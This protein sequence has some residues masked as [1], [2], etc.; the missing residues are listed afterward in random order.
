MN[1]SKEGSRDMNTY[2]EESAF[3]KGTRTVDGKRVWRHLQQIMETY[4]SY[5]GIAKPHQRPLFM[6]NH[7]DHCASCGLILFVFFIIPEFFICTLT[8]Q[9]YNKYILIMQVFILQHKTKL[10]LVP[11]FFKPIA[12]FG[13]SKSCKQILL[14]LC[15]SLISPSCYITLSKNTPHPKQ[16]VPV[17]LPELLIR[18]QCFLTQ[19]S[20]FAQCYL[21]FVGVWGGGGGGLLWYWICTFWTYN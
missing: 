19:L 21:P 18:G 9:K 17:R 20:T 8:I 16:P 2:R 6:W 11:P 5:Q 7:G 15:K 14:I 3:G 12:P 4:F 10:V 1:V 13:W